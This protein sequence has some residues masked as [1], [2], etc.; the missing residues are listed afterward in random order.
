MVKSGAPTKRPHNF[1]R[2]IHR[3][4]PIRVR[5]WY[6]R[7]ILVWWFNRMRSAHKKTL[8]Q[9][10]EIHFIRNAC[11]DWRSIAFDIAVGV[12]MIATSEIGKQQMFS[13]WYRD[14]YI[15][16]YIYCENIL[17]NNNVERYAIYIFIFFGVRES[18]VADFKSTPSNT[19]SRL[20]RPSYSYT[21]RPPIPTVLCIHAL[22]S[23][24]YNERLSALSMRLPNVD[25]VLDFAMR[26][27]LFD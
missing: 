14:R 2:L 13:C 21:R 6:G 26:H 1:P 5:R 17:D 19:G 12:M 27:W 10:K 18:A 9:R 3:N 7:M 16:F 25:M 23:H 15:H 20:R 8:A 4:T 22:R 11:N 24:I